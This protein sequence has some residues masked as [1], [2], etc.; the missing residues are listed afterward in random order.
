MQRLQSEPGQAFSDMFFQL[1]QNAAR[2]GQPAAVSLA[3]PGSPDAQE[4]ARQPARRTS[5][6]N[7]EV[8]E[9]AQI[10]EPP[11]EDLQDAARQMPPPPAQQP[12]SS[13]QADP[14]LRVPPSPAGFP[15]SQYGDPGQA[16]GLDPTAAEAGQFAK[17]GP[18]LTYDP[19]FMGGDPSQPLPYAQ[20]EQVLELSVYL[21]EEEE[22]R[23]QFT[24][25]DK[26][27][28]EA[29]LQAFM[30][31]YTR[32][33]VQPVDA[34]NSVF[35]GRRFVSS[36]LS[37]A[38]LQEEIAFTEAAVHV[39]EQQREQQAAI[40]TEIA[41]RMATAKALTERWKSVYTWGQLFNCADDHLEARLRARVAG[42]QVEML[43]ASIAKARQ[44]LAEL[45]RIRSSKSSGELGSEEFNPYS[46]VP[47]ARGTGTRSSRRRRV[48]YS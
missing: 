48:T 31:D 3:E 12:P 28:A 26:E 6:S 1:E 32:V 20:P 13:L 8:N 5:S 42:E 4:K 35:R 29:E 36:R 23:K 38:R 40:Q 43:D 22:H 27:R 34:A 7:A 41:T 37:S 44:R 2:A 18:V 46:E 17:Q 24:N 47:P 45:H 30:Q 16:P 39:L 11:S 21:L 19:T 15:G 14:Q 10:A 33:Q 25:Q 9:E